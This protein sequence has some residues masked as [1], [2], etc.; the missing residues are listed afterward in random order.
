[1][2]DTET[3]VRQQIAEQ[4]TQ[5]A[6]ARREASV[7][8]AAELDICARR[9]NDRVV[10]AYYTAADI[11]RTGSLRN[12]NDACTWCRNTRGGPVGHTTVE[13]MWEPCNTANDPSLKR[14]SEES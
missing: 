10:N 13:C 9:S 7:R 12:T 1:M 5:F 4:L 6:D 8:F 2:T 14:P 11:A 3:H